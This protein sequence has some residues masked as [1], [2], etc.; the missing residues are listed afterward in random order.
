MEAEQQDVEGPVGV[1]SPLAAG[2]TGLRRVGA[3]RVLHIHIMTSAC[4]LSSAFDGYRAV[5]LCERPLRR[6]ARC[7]DII[8]AWRAASTSC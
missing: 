1:L 8:R 2:D 7:L 3:G 6:D 4:G 5:P